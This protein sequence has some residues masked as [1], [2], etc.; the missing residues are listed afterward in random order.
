MSQRWGKV[1][2]IRTQLTTDPKL[3]TERVSIL[4]Q[5]QNLGK[6]SSGDDDRDEKRE[7]CV[8]VEGGECCVVDGH[9]HQAQEQQAPDSLELLQQAFL[10][11]DKLVE[12]LRLSDWLGAGGDDEDAG[13][14]VEDGQ[15]RQHH[16]KRRH[17]GVITLPEKFVN[18][19]R[20]SGLRICFLLLIN[21]VL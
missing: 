5:F 8:G 10:A 13:E 21:I 1:I 2:K 20:L 11:E 16:R 7:L 3:S 14:Q 18:T 15:Q 17:C 12:P 9:G 4:L 19:M 6:F